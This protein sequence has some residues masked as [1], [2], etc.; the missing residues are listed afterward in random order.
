MSVMHGHQT[1]NKYRR[2]SKC[3]KSPT[4]IKLSSA[5]FIALK[6]CKGEDNLYYD[7]QYVPVYSMMY[8][9]GY[10]PYCSLYY[11]LVLWDQ[12]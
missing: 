1:S 3:E 10:K 11:I 5:N 12:R 4:N 2:T 9:C 8:I 6:V 7:H